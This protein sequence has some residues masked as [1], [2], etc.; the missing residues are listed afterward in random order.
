MDEQVRERRAALRS[1]GRACRGRLTGDRRAA[2]TA[3]TVA[4]VLAEPLVAEA[5]G[6]VATSPIG[7]EVDLRSAW[8]VLRGRGQVVALPRVVGEHLE[9]AAVADGG[10]LRPGWRGVPEPTGPALDLGDGEGWV[11]LVPG[12]A[13]DAAGGRLGQGGGH[14]DRWLAAHPRVVP[15]GVALPCEL[16]TAALPLLPHDVRMAVVIAAEA[17]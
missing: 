13:F 3:A 2:V 15:V 14:F 4:A 6:V 17:G 5:R 9:I 7:G 11:A 16:H 8:P 12:L 10:R 1:A